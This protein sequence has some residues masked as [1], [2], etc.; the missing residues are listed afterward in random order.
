[1]HPNELKNR[2]AKAQRFLIA[3]DLVIPGVTAE[4][5]TILAPAAWEQ[6]ASASGENLPS[7][8]TIAS[9]IAL[10]KGREMALDAVRTGFAQQVVAP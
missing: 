1:M 2:L 10:A 8:A 3:A 9:V 6:F 7:D 5:L 4:T